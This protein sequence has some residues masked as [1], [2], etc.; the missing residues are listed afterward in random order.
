[1]AYNLCTQI[2]HISIGY[3]DI[4]MHQGLEITALLI[5]TDLGKYFRI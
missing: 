5:T 3:K 1:M 4:V 2:K